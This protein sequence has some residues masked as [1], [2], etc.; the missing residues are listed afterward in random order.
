MQEM[1]MKYKDDEII[2]QGKD[3]QMIG[4]KYMAE[5]AKATEKSGEM[6]NLMGN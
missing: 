4:E 6:K 1:G 5:N 3:M 2:S